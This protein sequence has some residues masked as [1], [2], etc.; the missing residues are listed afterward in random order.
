MSLLS[1]PP[2][3]L[4]TIIFVICIF[5]LLSSIRSLPAGTRRLSETIS[6]PKPP[7]QT[8]PTSATPPSSSSAHP[9]ADKGTNLEVNCGDYPLAKDVQLII[10][11]GA[12]E[13]YEK[14]P[15]QLVTE[16]RCFEDI[17]IFSDLEQDLG[18]YHVYDALDNVT[19]SV[20]QNSPDFK[21][22]RK[23]REYKETGQDIAEIRPTSGSGEGW[24]LDKFKFTHML[25]K[26]WALRPNRKWYVFI[27]A[28]TYLFRTTLLLW[29]ERLDAKKALYLGSPTSVGSDTFAH[30]GSG[31]VLSGVALAKFAKDKPGIGA[32][33]DEEVQS[34]AYGDH[35]L[36]KALKEAGVEL[37][38][39]WPMLQGEQPSTI[40]FGDGPD[41]GTRHWCQPLVT[42]HHVTSSEISD[43]WRFEQ[44]RPD[45]KKPVLIYEIYNQFIAPILR[46]SIDD[47][48]NRSDD[49]IYTAPENPNPRNKPAD[50]LS[51]LEKVAHKSFED[52]GRAC[53]EQTRCYQWAYFDNTCG[54]SHSYRLG[55]KK[56]PMD[57]VSYKS[58][59][60]LERIEKDRQEH[61]C[62]K[63]KWVD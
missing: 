41:S 12:N 44:Q 11:T 40:P 49:V 32:K 27:E 42:M 5:A 51:E 55:A 8:T 61:K 37:T 33:Y 10:K 22:Y 48:Y 1:P 57:G 35:M 21:Y 17:L 2:R 29:L 28:D 18:P 31:I 6:I 59:F 50:K 56:R 45:I 3:Y 25:E 46:K 54:F 58:G 53:E 26:T 39:A 24:N 47:W 19:E 62:T 13:I 38:R 23:L 60:L 15:T 43:V 52:C 7:S 34:F 20:K 9:A 36:M 30:G 14:L 16:L 4:Y 63:P